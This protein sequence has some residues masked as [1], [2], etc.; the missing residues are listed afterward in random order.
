MDDEGGEVIGV[1]A[2][3]ASAREAALNAN[4]NTIFYE[5]NLEAIFLEKWPI[6]KLEH[7]GWDTCESI[8]R[9]GDDDEDE[10][11]FEPDDDE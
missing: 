10:D 8:W 5:T 2:D 4:K 9:E 1:F 6:G 3:E 7:E 11:E